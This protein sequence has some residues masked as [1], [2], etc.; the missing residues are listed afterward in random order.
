MSS[1]EV[2]GSNE[3][4]LAA[5]DGGEGAY[6]AE[7]ADRFD[8]SIAG[9]RDAF[10]AAAEISAT[11]RVLDVGCGTGQTTRDA[12]RLASSGT[13]LGVDLSSA[14]LA[15]A[16]R[17]AA[18]EGLDNAS[19]EQ[20]DAQVHVFGAA[21]FDVVISRTAA[22]F[23]GDHAAAFRNLRRSMGDGGRL[24]L[25][26]WQALDGNEWLQEIAGA[27]SPGGPPKLPP[28]GVGPF[29]LSAPDRIADLLA[30]AGFVD[31]VPRAVA[32]P[33]WFGAD[34]DDAVTFI[35]G[36]QGWMLDGLDHDQRALATERLRSTCAAHA[37][38][39]G[40]TFRSAAWLTTARAG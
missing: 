11:D 32:A 31:V 25:L 27:L 40:V 22:M 1:I 21:S 24:V 19:F 34:A 6:W 17:R 35:L 39:V 26:T 29:S 12:A 37:S 13:A 5:W 7:H 28:P 9:Y 36:L 3:A 4:Q 15:V 2:H 18:D 20:A 10:S 23:F 16:R 8:R 33:M 38:P 14:M 30:D